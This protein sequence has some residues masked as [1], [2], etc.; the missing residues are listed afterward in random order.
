M[1]MLTGDKE[2]TAHSVAISCGFL[3]AAN[4][5]IKINGVSEEDI[6]TQF[7]AC[8]KAVSHNDVNLNQ[9]DIVNPLSEK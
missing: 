8:L 4:S 9:V 6:S 5:L 1:W 7:Q 3:D 2:E